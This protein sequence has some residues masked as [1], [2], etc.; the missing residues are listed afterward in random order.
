MADKP[1]EV[2]HVRDRPVGFRECG[3]HHVHRVDHGSDRFRGDRVLAAPQTPEKPIERVQRSGNPP[4]DCIQEVQAEQTMKASA[5]R[6]HDR[7]GVRQTAARVFGTLHTGSGLRT[8]DIRIAVTS[9]HT[10]IV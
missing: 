1:N 2:T 6:N 4:L 10:P 3:E 8:V 9:I 7:A 5:I